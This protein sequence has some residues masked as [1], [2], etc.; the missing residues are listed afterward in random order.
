[1]RFLM[2]VLTIL[3][4]TPHTTFYGNHTKLYIIQCS[5]FKRK[6]MLVVVCSC[7]GVNLLQN[8]HMSS[9]RH[10]CLSNPDFWSHFVSYIGKKFSIDRKKIN[11]QLLHLKNYKIKKNTLFKGIGR[12]YLVETS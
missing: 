2:T 11:D 12:W 10:F 8:L 3:L 4:K 5:L 6:N 1:M 7:A 9:W